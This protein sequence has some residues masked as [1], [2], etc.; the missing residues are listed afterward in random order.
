MIYSGEIVEGRFLSRPNRFIAFVLVEGR[1]VKCHVKNTGRC[2][3]LLVPGCKVYL[4]RAENPARS[5]LFDLI[6]VEKERENLPP[7]LIN[8]DSQAPNKAVEE[9]LRG[10]ALFPLGSEVR[11]EVTFHNSRFDFQ[12]REPDG[13]VEYL[14]VKG[15]T[16][17]ENG[18]VSFPDA[19]TERGVKHIMELIEAKIEGY[20]ATILI[21]IQM[22]GVKKFVPNWRTHREFGL[23]LREAEKK[24]V[25]ILAFDS[26]VTPSS[27]TV[28]E[29]VT[30]DLGL[31]QAEEQL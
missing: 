11:G 30:V 16:L 3:E 14:E 18:I 9:Y 17:E 8:M 26:I 19:P 15:C 27:L 20:G 28:S 12:I 31:D 10:G 29:R 21:L 1:E 22:K 23:A 5:T 24:G 6:A 7:L 13:R 4:E 2:R 25:R